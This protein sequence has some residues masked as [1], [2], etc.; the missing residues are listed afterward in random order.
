MVDRFDV[1]VELHHINLDA[2]LL[3][4]FVDDA[5]AAG[6][7]P[8]HPAGVDRPADAELVFLCSLGLGAEQRCK[9]G[10]EQGGE[11]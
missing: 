11:T 6:V 10:G 1:I 4:P 5:L 7:F 8:R 3:R 9:R 2:V